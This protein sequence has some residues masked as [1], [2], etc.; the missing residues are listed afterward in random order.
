MAPE[1]GG[2]IRTCKD[3]SHASSGG[4]VS[5]S[6]G[7]EIRDDFPN[8]GGAIGKGG[9]EHPPLVKLI[10]DGRGEMDSVV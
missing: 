2:A 6:P 8:V 1:V 3:A 9:E 7:G 4:V 10:M 5:P